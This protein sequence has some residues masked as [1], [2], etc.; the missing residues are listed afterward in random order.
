[1]CTDISYEGKNHEHLKETD[2]K[3][4]KNR[5][6]SFLNK[7]LFLS[8]SLLMINCKK[9]QFTTFSYIHIL[10]LMTVQLLPS[11]GIDSGH[12]NKIEVTKCQFHVGD[13]ITLNT[14]SCC[15]LERNQSWLVCWRTR[16]HGDQRA[17]GQLRS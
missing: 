16:D 13:S 5:L 9:S 10:F 11:E 17:D 3:T 2:T 12:K 15:F 7:S 6:V 4:V 8:P 14:S 1:M